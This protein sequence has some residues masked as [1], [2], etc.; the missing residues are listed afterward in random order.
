MIDEMNQFKSSIL[1][2]ITTF[3]AI[4]LWACDPAKVLMI[5][6]SNKPNTSVSIY[7]NKVLFP[8][9]KANG[10]DKIKLVIPSPNTPEHRDTMFLY[11]IGTWYGDE[12]MANFAKDIDSIIIVNT[13]NTLV[14]NTQKDII[15]Y[16]LK[17]RH[18]FAKSRL[19]IRAK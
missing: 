3:V 11:G 5:S 6:S 16:L 4:S 8:R 2:T 18:G 1:Y 13:K 14:L 7:A 17:H 19:T 9:Y 12:Y 10:P 15:T